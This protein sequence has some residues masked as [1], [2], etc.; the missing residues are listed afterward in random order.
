M[1]IH[2]GFGKRN[3][4]KICYWYT[5]HPK[6]IHVWLH[7]VGKVQLHFNR[8]CYNEITMWGLCIAK[9]ILQNMTV[10][11]CNFETER[12]SQWQLYRSCHTSCYV[13][14]LCWGGWGQYCHRD[15]RRVAYV[16]RH[17]KQTDAL[18]Y[19]QVHC[20]PGD[21]ILCMQRT[22]HEPHMDK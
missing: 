15:N 4:E 20:P 11:L 7:C 5:L 1:H 18:N 12:S 21:T 2:T 3:L 8:P 17:P 19:V 9:R 16:E 13:Y 10:A 14:N 6:I 22:Q